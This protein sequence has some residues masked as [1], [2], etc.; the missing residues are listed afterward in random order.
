MI[1]VQNQRNLVIATAI[2]ALGFG[3]YY[4]R[5][6]NERKAQI[7]KKVEKIVSCF[8]YHQIGNKIF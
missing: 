1:A 5:S 2:G 6:R 3:F 4:L 8:L 7:E